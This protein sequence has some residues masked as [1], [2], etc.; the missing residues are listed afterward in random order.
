MTNHCRNGV[1]W[2]LL[3]LLCAATLGLRM[4]RAEQASDFW[5]KDADNRRPID[6]QGEPVQERGFMAT[7]VDAVVLLVLM[8]LLACAATIAFRRAADARNA[9]PSVVLPHME[10]M[11]E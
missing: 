7:N 8:V 1:C 4:T 5:V 6:P 2:L 3:A 9:R 11:F 10:T